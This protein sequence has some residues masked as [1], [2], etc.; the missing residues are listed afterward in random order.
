MSDDQLS[1]H[2][3]LALSALERALA[4]DDPDY[5][6]RFASAARTLDGRG[7]SWRAALARWLSRRNG[8]GFGT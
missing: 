4:E 7:S 6:E 5:V 1:E 3:W 2:E 8:R